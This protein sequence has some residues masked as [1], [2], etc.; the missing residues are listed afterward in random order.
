MTTYASTTERPA[1]AEMIEGYRDGLD[2]SSPE[3]NANRSCSYRHGF[4]AGRSDR[5]IK[6]AWRTADEGRQMADAAM[7]ADDMDDAYK[8]TP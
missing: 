7:A 2:L 8:E 1:N 4:M 3:P 6:P 5:H